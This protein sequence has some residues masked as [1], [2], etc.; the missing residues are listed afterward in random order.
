MPR[1]LGSIR[2]ITKVIPLVSSCT[3]LGKVCSVQ[4]LEQLVMD[5]M[6]TV[7]SAQAVGVPPSPPS[8]KV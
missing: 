8:L 1:L 4:S 2:T 7:C 3:L 5:Q 6:C